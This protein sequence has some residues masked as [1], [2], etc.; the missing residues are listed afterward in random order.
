MYRILVV[1]DQRVEVETVSWLIMKHKLLLKVSEAF[2]G[3][4]AL[5]HLNAQP[6]DILFTDI[7]M[8]FMDGIELARCAKKLQPSIRII[9]YSAYGEFQYAQQ[10]IEIGVQH[11]IMKP[12]APANFIEVMGKVIESCDSDLEVKSKIARLEEGYEK[13]TRYERESLFHALLHGY[14]WSLTLQNT[15]TDSDL[16]HDRHWY[17]MIFVDTRERLFDISGN[18]FNT[19]LAEW[20]DELFVLL[21]LNERQ[22][23][24]IV[25]YPKESDITAKIVAYAKRIRQFFDYEYVMSS[26]IVI[27]NPVHEPA[28][29]SQEFDRMEEQLDYR[30]YVNG[31]TIWNM[32]NNHEGDDGCIM[33]VESELA[34]IYR[35][36]EASDYYSVRKGIDVLVNRLRQSGKFSP[37]YAKLLFSELVRKL[38]KHA[39]EEQSL[40]MAEMLDQVV[41]LKHIDQLQN[42]SESIIDILN[43]QKE[44]QFDEQ[45]RKVIQQVVE[46]IADH[47]GEDIGLEQIAEHFS[48][49]PS[50]MAY[51]FKG[52]MGKS[53][54]KYITELRLERAAELLMT[55]FIK[56]VEIGRQVGYPHPSYFAMLFK[57]RYGMTPAQYREKVR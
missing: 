54:G 47:Y 2:N 20:V 50:H 46:Y 48:F 11:Y 44:N 6:F 38:F 1:D 31:S 4:E 15:M 39:N 14:E 56:I 33:D 51:L 27:G 45:N 36:I 40:S 34:I 26:F 22:S 19:A 3:K 35:Q 25:I 57:N 55:T 43:L 53:I 7:K 9:M 41:K 42:L 30:F 13:V 8:P 12:L 23:V 32:T 5:D 10:A 16:Q 18:R 17:Q 21:H 49:S 52:S 28:E 29:L 37:L 24:I